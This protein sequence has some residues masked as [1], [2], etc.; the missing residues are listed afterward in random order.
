MADIARMNDKQL[1]E[2]RKLIKKRCCNFD[3]GICLLLDWPF[4]NVCPQYN[5]YS[6]SCKWF[7]DAV[8][9]NDKAFEQEIYNAHPHIHRCAVCKKRYTPT[10]SRRKYCPACAQSVR[11]A[12]QAK[13]VRQKRA[14]A[15]TIQIDF[16]LRRNHFFECFL[17]GQYV[18]IRKTQM[19]FQLSTRHPGLMYLGALQQHKEVDDFWQKNNPNGIGSKRSLTELN[20]VSKTC[21]TVIVFVSI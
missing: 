17:R 21:S 20:R 19:T 15:S 3:H 13:W 12:Q 9:P 4:C 8:L 16:P 5:S 14:Q 1:K 11:R 2:A 6:V 10:G 7:R 18:Y